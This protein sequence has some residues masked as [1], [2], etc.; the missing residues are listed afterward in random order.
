MVADV[1]TQALD[2]SARHPAWKCRRIINRASAEIGRTPL[3]DHAIA[4]EYK[5]QPIEPRVTARA[6]FVLAVLREELA[7]RQI[8]LR[9]VARQFG[10]CGRRRRNMLAEHGL[11]HPVA[12]LHR[13]CAQT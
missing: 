11:H 10:Y 13:A 5:A 4:F 8:E 7:Q 2:A 3:A 12:A 6:R 9:F 1:R